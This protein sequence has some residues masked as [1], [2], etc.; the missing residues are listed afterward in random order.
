MPRPHRD[1][2]C[3]DPAIKAVLI[4]LMTPMIVLTFVA[5]VAMLGRRLGWW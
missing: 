5:M 1:I 4:I 2:G 3:V